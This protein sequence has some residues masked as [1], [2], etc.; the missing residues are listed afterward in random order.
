MGDGGSIDVGIV[1]NI[2]DA[3]TTLL[4][5]T[6]FGISEAE[7]Y[8][9]FAN[10][11]EQEVVRVAWE[12]WIIGKACN[13]GTS[14]EKGESEWSDIELLR[15]E[16]EG[17]LSSLSAI[18]ATDCTS[19]NGELSKDVWRRAFRICFLF[20]DAFFPDFDANFWFWKRMSL[21]SRLYPHFPSFCFETKEL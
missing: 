19:E 2:L 12:S 11:E 14:V 5:N 8:V 6:F 1:W 18:L 21:V 15:R 3:N 9:W 4:L 20:L 17:K 7:L 13:L 10:G 16:A